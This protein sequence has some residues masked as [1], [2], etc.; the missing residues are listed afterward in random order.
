MMYYRSDWPEVGLP[1]PLI[2]SSLIHF[3]TCLDNRDWVQ[4]TKVSET[5]FR[6]VATKSEFE[7]YLYKFPVWN[8]RLEVDDADYILL[9]D[10]LDNVSLHSNI[11]DAFRQLLDALPC[12]RA[13][14]SSKVV[15]DEPLYDALLQFGFEEVE[16]RRLYMCRVSDLTSRPSPSSLRGIRFTS[17]AATTPEQVSTYREHTMVLLLLHFTQ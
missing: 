3:N 5:T 16:H 2:E 11:K 15:M 17:L 8:L 14:V 9:S 6:W 4:E 1:T 12:D 7:S 10:R 13:Y